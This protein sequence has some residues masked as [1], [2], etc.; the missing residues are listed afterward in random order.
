MKII[1]D[2]CKKSNA[3]LMFLC[4]NNKGEKEQIYICF[5]CMAERAR[6]IAR[7]KKEGE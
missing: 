6:N 7:T 3:G 1:C 2:F 5:D 4:E